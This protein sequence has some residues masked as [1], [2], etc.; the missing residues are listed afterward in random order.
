MKTTNENKKTN[1]RGN[2]K[3]S[4]QRLMILMAAIMMSTALVGCDETNGDNTP[5]GNINKKLT[6][7]WHRSDTDSQNKP[8]SHYYIFRKDGTFSFLQG[9]YNSSSGYF[10]GSEI[11][12]KY[13][14]SKG[15]VFFKD[16]SYNWTSGDGEEHKLLWKD[17]TVEYSIETVNGRITL[18]IPRLFETDY[19]DINGAVAFYQNE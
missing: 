17:I 1:R 18:Y 15:K 11:K 14:T 9:D 2:V 19:I 5:T 16:V 13:S 8:R 6:G 3:S 4:F 10:S 7:T 12:G